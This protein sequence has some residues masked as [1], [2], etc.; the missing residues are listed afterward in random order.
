[1]PGSLQSLGHHD[2]RCPPR[3]DVSFW[4]AWGITGRSPRARSGAGAPGASGSARETHVLPDIPPPSS[5]PASVYA[6]R[7][8]ARRAV[9]AALA[10]RLDRLTYAR[11][12]AFL[13]MLVVAGVGFGTQL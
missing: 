5:A 9:V 4:A 7:L 3:K 11:L 6:D 13:L 12:A 2:L 10:A 1:M 8:A